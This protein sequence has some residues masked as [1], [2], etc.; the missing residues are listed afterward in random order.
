MSLVYSPQQIYVPCLFSPSPNMHFQDPD[1]HWPISRWGNP[2][3]LTFLQS[4]MGVE[5]SGL[6]LPGVWGSSPCR[7]TASWSLPITYA[8]DSWA[9]PW[10]RGDIFREK[11]LDWAQEAELE[12]F[13][14]GIKE[15]WE[16]FK[17]L[18]LFF[19]FFFFFFFFLLFRA[20]TCGIWKF[21]G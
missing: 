12:W 8:P 10:G 1:D 9:W 15:Q 7:L 21:L 6:H 18:S 17:S 16:L 5:G 3:A 2:Q 19:F 14:P 20:C 4:R 11:C 13:L